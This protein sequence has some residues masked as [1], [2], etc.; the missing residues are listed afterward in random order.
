MYT[1]IIIDDEEHAIEG[2]KRYLKAVPM[3]ELIATFSDSL[4]ALTAL[5]QLDRVDLILMDVDMPG[6]S[7]IELSRE[8]AGK[9]NKLVFTTGHTKY[10]YDAFKVGADDYL[11]KPYTL[12]EFIICIEKLFGSIKNREVDF[13][14]PAFLVKSKEEDNK[15]VSVRFDAII[16][17]ESKLNYVM[18]YTADKKVTTYMSLTEMFAILSRVKGFLQFHRSFIIAYDYIQHI[19]GNTIRMTN[20]ME[21]TVRD[22]YK[23]A[24]FEFL[25][26]YLIK[27]ARSAK[28]PIS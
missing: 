7:G 11:L 3:L 25:S 14:E 17:V 4:L 26:H 1:C 13:N 2:L 15:I 18:L 21:I 27:P 12:G 6:I 9:A 24:F 8:I 5:R 28:G 22:H 10:G 23:K 16:A 20:G 19:D